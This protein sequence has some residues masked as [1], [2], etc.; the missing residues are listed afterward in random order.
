MESRNAAE[1]N[2]CAPAASR[3]KPQKRLINGQ[4]VSA[5][6]GNYIAGAHADVVQGKRRERLFGNIV[7]AVA[8]RRYL[9]KFDNEVAPRNIGSQVLKVESIGATLPPDIPIPV[10]TNP[11]ELLELEEIEELVDPQDEEA[12]SLCPRT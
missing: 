1:S 7:K 4:R 5:C 3:T 11:R 12:F 2:A 9:V 6:V 8:E 10:P